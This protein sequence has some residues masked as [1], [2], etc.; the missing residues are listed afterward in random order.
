M[1]SSKLTSGRLL[2]NPLTSTIARFKKYTHKDPQTRFKTIFPI[3]PPPGTNLQI[4]GKFI[5][6]VGNAIR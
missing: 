3:F 6:L 5:R 2:N 4:P 1:I